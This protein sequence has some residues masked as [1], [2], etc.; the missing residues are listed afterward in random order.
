MKEIHEVIPDTRVVPTIHCA[1]DPE[2]LWTSEKREVLGVDPEKFLE[3]LNSTYF[4]TGMSENKAYKMVKDDFK[5]T[6]TLRNLKKDLD[7]INE[8][9]SE[10]GIKLP[11]TTHANEI[12]KKAA[13]NGFGDLD[14]TGI[15]AYLKKNSKV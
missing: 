4:K 12:F 15:L 1:V 11:M 8:A 13:E 5:P 3:I 7:T 14:Y 6:F 9:A 2:A 10:Y